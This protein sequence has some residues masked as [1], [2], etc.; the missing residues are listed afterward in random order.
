MHRR[1]GWTQLQLG[2]G[3]RIPSSIQDGQHVDVGPD[4]CACA[5]AGWLHGVDE[6]W[7]TQ[8]REILLVIAVVCSL[9][10][11]ERALARRRQNVARRVGS[12]RDPGRTR[13]TRHHRRGACSMR[14]RHRGRG[15]PTDRHMPSR[16]RDH[17]SRRDEGETEQEEWPA[18]CQGAERAGNEG[19]LGP[20]TFPC[21]SLSKRPRHPRS[22]ISVSPLAH[23]CPMCHAVPSLPV[24]GAVPSACA[25]MIPSPPL[26]RGGWRAEGHRRVGG[27]CL[28]LPPAIGYVHYGALIC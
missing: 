16:E 20:A 26:G 21:S 3:H 13:R 22:A 12:E 5:A 9:R 24:S 28:V 18:A 25:K 15:S 27:S 8:P 6:D 10:L 7:R 14:S 2:G 1:M 19:C 4:V 11:E 23:T 17:Q